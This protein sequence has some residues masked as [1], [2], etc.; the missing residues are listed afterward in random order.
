MVR[1]ISVFLV[2][3]VFIGCKDPKLISPLNS[4]NTNLRL[5]GYYFAKRKSDGQSFNNIIFIYKN[6]VVFDCLSIEKS[7]VNSMD[8]YIRTEIL[9]LTWGIVNTNFRNISIEF[10]YPSSGGPSPV[11]IR[12]GQILNDST[13]NF[14]SIEKQ[15]GK[16]KKVIDETYHFRQF[17]PKPDSTNNFI[18]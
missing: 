12:K 9:K 5:N 18:K 3:F 14:T 11:F 7:D 4:L 8:E 10:W 17:S 16:N 15:N 13:F 6:G 2:F 1:N